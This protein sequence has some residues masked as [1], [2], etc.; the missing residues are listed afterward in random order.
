[1]LLAGCAVGPDYKPPETPMPAAWTG[2]TAAGAIQG[3]R[4]IARTAEVVDWWSVFKDPTL[5][6][7]V[8]RAVEGN[9]DL[10]QAAARIR[11]ARAARGV[12]GAG[13]W[14]TATATSSYQRSG[15][16][17]AASTGSP[18]LFLVGLD[19]AWEMDIF[20]GV[21]RGIEAADAGVQAAIEDQRGVFV[22]LAAETALDYV[23]LR[24]LQRQIAIAQD[25]LEAQRRIADVTRKRFQGGFVGKLDVANADALV[26]TTQ[27]QIPVLETSARQTIYSLSVLLGR[28][29]AALLAELSPAAPVPAPPS[30]VPV[31]LPSDLL[32]RRPDIRAAEARLHA[33]TANIGV[34]TADLFPKF[35]LTGAIGFQGDRLASLASWGGRSWSLGPGVSWSL[36]DAGRIRANIQVQDALQEQALLTYR[37]AV[38]T[39][40][41]EVE[42][43]LIACDKEQEHHN[44]LADAVAANKQ[45]VTLSEDLYKQ[46]QTDFL[47][48]L[49]A[50][51]ALYASE[52][53]LVQSE[54]ALS[55]DV[56]GLYKALGGGWEN[57]P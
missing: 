41:Q 4:T 55:V 37:Q 10:A 19:A 47:N 1:M 6:S 38:L 26:A 31:G 43:A 17:Q 27:S 50:R 5:D 34:A 35:T 28:E 44:A 36:F 39:A 33:A 23:T 40:L 25:N 21:R 46:G 30:E 2:T 12:A 18:N 7:L 53:A 8:R 22:T 29:P 32:R 15:G 49:S 54:Q 13:Q 20:G 42:N 45:A 11:Q 24:G 51:R 56:I 57:H 3:T 9:L 48:V 16:G 14:P 52:D